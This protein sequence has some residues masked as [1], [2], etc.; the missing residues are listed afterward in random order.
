MKKFITSIVDSLS[1]LTFTAIIIAAL[2]ITALINILEKGIF[3]IL[4]H[5]LP[6]YK[7]VIRS[8]FDFFGFFDLF[9]SWWFKGLLV[10]FFINLLVCT[11]KRI[12][13]TIRIL[14]PFHPE[15]E[16]IPS[17]TLR[18]ERVILDSLSSEFEHTLETFLSKMLP[19]LSIHRSNETTFFFSQK[20]RY[21]FLGY[22]LAHIG[23]MCILIGG[24]VSSSGYKGQIY[25]KEGEAV[26]EFFARKNENSFVKQ[27]H[28]TM[29]LDRCEAISNMKKV[30]PFTKSSY[31]NIITILRE[32]K[33]VKTE[34]LEGYRTFKYK[35]FRIAQLADS[36][37][38][39][40]IASLKVTPKKPL[41]ESKVYTFREREFFNVPETGHLIRLWNISSSSKAVKLEIY[42]E[43]YELLYS[44]LVYSDK[45]KSQGLWDKDYEF[46]LLGINENKT[47]SP[48]TRLE[49][50]Y[51]PGE[52]LIWAGF[53]IA[54]IGF[55]IMFLLL[56][57]KIWIKIEKI[58]GKYHITMAGWI[59]R[60]P[61]VIEEHFEDVR[62]LAINI[63]CG[64]I[65]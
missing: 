61:E 57:Q 52:N 59:S 49:V 34:V 25:V 40:L 45:R 32:G 13:Q 19:H 2:T 4:E 47:T 27:L 33:K 65:Q 36:K 41:G 39:N 30:E 55:S 22:Y 51:E 37:K 20:G 44:P 28:F 9:H 26:D 53:Y 50:S 12:P 23:L 64:K 56:H 6:H 46:T 17:N 24:I 54:I 43:K 18:N 58:E 11:L 29:R 1:S 8:I 60:N 7:V 21:S 38:D 15:Y 10:C 62:Q 16:S 63:N 3:S 42:G 31:R 48:S 14:M 5:Y 35:G